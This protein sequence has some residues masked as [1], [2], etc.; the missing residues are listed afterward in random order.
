[1]DWLEAAAA[2]NN[3][4][5]LANSTKHRTQRHNEGGNNKI[6]NEKHNKNKSDKEHKAKAKKK[7]S[8]TGLSRLL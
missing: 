2:L 5:K 8:E 1:L 7:M 3:H 6:S 4:L